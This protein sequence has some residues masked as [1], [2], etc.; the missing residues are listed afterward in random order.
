MANVTIEQ[1]SKAK[2]IIKKNFI[3]CY[4]E[5][6]KDRTELNDHDYGMKYGWQKSDKLMN[7]K[8]NLTAV[9]FYQKYINSFYWDSNQWEK[10]FGIDRK[11]IW[12]LTIEKWL[13]EQ[14]FWKHGKSTVYYINQQRAKEIWK[15]AKGK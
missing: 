13:S 15:E 6:M 1:I 12:Q 11:I 4:Y 5:W 14:M 10:K 3:D 8:D 9:T 2:E 7:L